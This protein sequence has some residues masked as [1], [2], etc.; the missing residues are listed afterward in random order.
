MVRRLFPLCILL[1]FISSCEPTPVSDKGAVLAKAHG[2]Y[3][4][5]SDLKDVIPVG[6]SARDSL[7]LTKTL[8]TTG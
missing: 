4:Y 7:L 5:E 1:A 6:T 3:L 8:L 2:N